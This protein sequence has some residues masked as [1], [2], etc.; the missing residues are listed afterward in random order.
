MNVTGFNE[1]FNFDDS[2]PID[3]AIAKIEKLNSVYD[4]LITHAKANSQKYAESLDIISK[5]AEKLE[6]QLID[7]DAAEKAQQ[8]TIIKNASET[9]RLLTSQQNVTKSF[10][11]EQAAVAM[12]TEAQNK[13]KTAKESLKKEAILEAGSLA[14]LKKELKESAALYESYGKATSQAVKDETLKKVKDLSKSVAEGEKAIKDAKKGVDLAAGSY[15][16]LA[17]RVADAKKRLKEMEGGIGGNTKEFKQLKK[18]AAEGTKQLKEF[19]TAVGDNQRNVGN[20]KDALSALPPG[21]QGFASGIQTVTKAGLAFIASPIGLV[22]GAVALA[23]G[24]LAAY[25]KR[26]TEGQDDL[27]K[28]MAVSNAI[29][30]TL[31]SVLEPI[32][33]AIFDLFTDFSKLNGIVEGV[34]KAITYAFENP[35]KV[36]KEFGALLY[37]QIVNRFFAVGVA[38]EGVYKLLTGDI[39]EGF[40]LLGDAAIQAVA[41]IEDGV[42][43]LDK[44]LSPILKKI[45]AEAQKRIALA[46][47]I[48]GLEAKIRKDK[49]ADV[50]D[51]A[52]T[53]LSVAQKLVDARNKQRFTDEE[54]YSF[55]RKANQEL[56]DQLNGDLDLT[57]EQIKLVDLQ[58]RQDGKTYELLEQRAQLEASLYNQQTAFFNARKK[59]QQQEIALIQ[60]IDKETQDRIKREA[61]AER[62]LSN[63]LTQGKIDANKEILADERSTNEQ[64]IEAIH[65]VNNAQAELAESAR[66]QAITVAKEEAI[67]RIQ[68]SEEALSTIYNN[69]SISISDRIAQ[70]RAAKE[71]LISEDQAYVDTRVK[72]TEQFFSAIDKSNDEAAKALNDNVFKQLEKDFKQLDDTVKTGADNQIDALNQAYA[73]GN[74]TAAQLVRDRQLVQ[75]QAQL[76]SLNSQL[77]YLEEYKENLK[78]LGYDTT[79][80]EKEIANTRVAISTAATDKQIENEKK[81]KD[82]VLA[83]GQEILTASLEIIAN[84][85]EARIDDLN[86]EIDLQNEQKEKSL[87]IAGDDA[88]AKELIE[89][90]FAN[91]QKEIQ[92]QILAERRKQA[93]FEKAVALTQAGINI[94]LGISNALGSSI[95]PLSFILAAAVAAAGAF[96]IAAIASKPIPSYFVGTKDSP[97]GIALVGDRGREIVKEPGRPAYMAD[98]PQYRYLKRHSIVYTN[99]ETESL[100]S[101]SMNYGDGFGMPDNVR[102]SFDN[103]RMANAPVLDSARIASAV[104]TSASDI[105][106]AINRMPRDYYD[107]RGF[108]SYE[109]GENARV[110][111][112]DNRYKLIS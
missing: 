108:R 95:P 79:A 57:R 66:D 38:I 69:E 31:L 56:E 86:H 83:L 46:V 16:S 107:E 103:N 21:L 72:I 54:R 23:V 53:E 3:E 87:K 41:G 88:Q 25:F 105:V 74:I 24:S 50:I 44:T 61:D 90:N 51:D 70:E 10:K 29:F 11:D 82:A 112:L 42:N 34:G 65:E 12:L 106:G 71:L 40:K 73:D 48:A 85:A 77:D 91:K 1:L 47:Q 4:T 93:V 59:R 49:I 75:D 36:L 30:Q 99:P 78:K 104:A 64:R 98:V 43:K 111:R 17:A 18:F 89:Q 28:V 45:D 92:R 80:I 5:S 19:D 100:L 110:I 109:R 101:D 2:T 14:A 60:E 67:A 63:F 35:G 96:Q 84:K 94:A 8:E 32:G 81:L 15:N 22:I 6:K 62:S 55:L 7:L 26:S 39:K 37:D 58:I 9:E 97:E 52:K 68:L 27:N 33:K 13:L 76:D 102:S 20:Y